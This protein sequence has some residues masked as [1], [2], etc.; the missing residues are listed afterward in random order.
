MMAGATFHD[1]HVISGL[2]VEAKRHLFN[3]LTDAKIKLQL[4]RLAG[5]H[6]RPSLQRPNPESL[7]L[8]R[9]IGK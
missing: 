9:T 2:H 5:A 3:S 8:Q 6:E 7:D 1:A 4:K